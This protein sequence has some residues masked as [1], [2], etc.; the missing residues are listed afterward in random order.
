M[1]IRAVTPRMT[2]RSSQPP[3]RKRKGPFS[4][5]AT[6]ME[7][8]F[9]NPK[10]VTLR[11]QLT[12]SLPP[13][14]KRKGP[15]LTTV[16]VTEA[17]SPSPKKVTLRVQLKTAATVKK[18]RQINLKR[19]WPKSGGAPSPTA[20]MTVQTRSQQR[21]QQLSLKSTTAAVTV[22]ALWTRLSTTEST[23]A[24]R[25]KESHATLLQ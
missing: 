11:L 20:V 7:A 24:Q 21:K 25:R 17:M 23:P 19:N 3:L 1:L 2:K 4:M 16:T 5:T 14:G 18:C 10:K 9:P 6:V 13:L 12:M 22:K 15:F 8:M